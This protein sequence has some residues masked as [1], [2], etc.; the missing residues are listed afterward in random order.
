MLRSIAEMFA[1]SQ[2]PQAGCPPASDAAGDPDGRV[3]AISSGAFQHAPLK[4]LQNCSDFKF[5]SNCFNFN[6]L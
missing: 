1:G 6:E 3:S 5:G 4:G 2:V